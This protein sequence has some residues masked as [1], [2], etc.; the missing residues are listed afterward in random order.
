ML[1][2]LIEKVKGCSP[3]AKYNKHGR[4]KLRRKDKDVV[5]S[6]VEMGEGLKK[7]DLQAVG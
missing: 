7:F 3:G 2:I 1:Q 6:F 5:S 4:E